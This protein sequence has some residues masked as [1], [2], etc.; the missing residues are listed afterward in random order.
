MGPIFRLTLKELLSKK[1]LL[2][3]FILT[4]IYLVLYGTGLHFINA[5]GMGDM[6]E[7]IV[8]LMAYSQLISMGL[9]FASFIVCLFAVFA[10]VGA[11]SSEVD[12]GVMI[13]I[14]SKPVRRGEI[15]V[16]KFMG[17][18]VMLM[19]YSAF[20]YYSIYFLVDIMLD[21]RLGGM[22]SGYLLFTLQPLVLLAVTFWGT[23]FLPTVANGVAVFI[24]YMFGM[25]GGMIEQIGYAIEKTAAVNVGIVSSLIMPVDTIFRQMINV[26]FSQTPSLSILNTMGPFMSL[27]QPSHWMMVYVLIYVLGCVFMATRIF[28]AK[29]I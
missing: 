13:S 8:K 14:I 26:I 2:V 18:A 10:G 29:E 17:Y 7:Q 12:N 3:S 22:V 20:I 4:V 6:T 21:L 1:I 24:L 23:T 25:I 16:G 28:K 27:K 15:I 19:L 11:I 5:K 9:Y